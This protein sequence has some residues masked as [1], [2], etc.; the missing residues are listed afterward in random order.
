LASGIARAGAN[1]SRGF[2]DGRNE[3]QCKQRLHDMGRQQKLHCQSQ[4]KDATY[5][6]PTPV[7]DGCGLSLSSSSF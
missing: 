1:R 4:V 5:H 3:C 2:L 7:I 6:E